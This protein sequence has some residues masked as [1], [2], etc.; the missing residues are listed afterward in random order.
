MERPVCRSSDVLNQSPR[1]QMLAC[2]GFTMLE[3]LVACV[4]LGVVVLAAMTQVGRFEA[5][6]D[7]LIVRGEIEDLRNFVRNGVDC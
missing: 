5:F 7:H 6:V 3:A 4:V 1:H 2:H